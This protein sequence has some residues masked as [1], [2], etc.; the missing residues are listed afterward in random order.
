MRQWQT[1]EGKPLSE[2]VEDLRVFD[3]LP[4][5]IDLTR[6]RMAPGGQILAGQMVDLVC[7]TLQVKSPSERGLQTYLRLLGAIPEEL[8]RKATQKVLQHHKYNRMPTPADW[9]EHVRPELEERRQDRARAEH[10]LRVVGLVKQRYGAQARMEAPERPTE[11]Q[12][13]RVSNIVEQAIRALKGG[14]P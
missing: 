8:L 3:R 14:K 1:L 12:K 7:E 13:A 6:E 10:M 2:L 11:E 4:E 9:Y 5:A